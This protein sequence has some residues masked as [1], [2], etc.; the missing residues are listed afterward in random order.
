VTKQVKQLNVVKH[1]KDF[2]VG[3]LKQTNL[4]QHIKGR[5]KFEF[6]KEKQ[7]PQ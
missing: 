7:L 5:M 2:L 3:F 1:L 4:Y 6:S